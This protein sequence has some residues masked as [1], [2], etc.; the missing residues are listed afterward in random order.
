MKKYLESP[1][2]SSITPPSTVYHLY[3]TAPDDFDTLSQTVHKHA[4]MRELNYNKVH[5]I[6]NHILYFR[7]NE[8]YKKYAATAKNFNFTSEEEFIIKDHPIKSTIQINFI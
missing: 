8:Y 6:Y 7:I 2:K 5:P 4:L 3:F 1:S